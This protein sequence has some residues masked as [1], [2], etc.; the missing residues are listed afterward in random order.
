VGW[1]VQDPQDQMAIV[2]GM[3]LELVVMETEMARAVEMEMEEEMDKEE[4]E[5]LGVLEGLVELEV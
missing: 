2:H 4:A 5:E 3:D 1:G